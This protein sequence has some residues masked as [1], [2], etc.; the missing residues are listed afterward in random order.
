M[1]MST[2]MAFE[3]GAAGIAKQQYELLK[4]QQ[5]MASGRRVNSASD[6]PIAAAHIIDVTSAQE[7]NKRYLAN[8]TSARN[9]ISITESNLGQANSIL[10]DIRT[11]LVQA[12]DGSYGDRERADV[13]KEI[14]VRAEELL[15]L[16]N[17]KD[18]NGR[19]VFSGFQENIPAFRQTAA[20][21]VF[22]GDQGR[23]EVQVANGR[24]LGTSVSAADIFDRVRTGNGV[25]T[26]A[27]AAG[28]TGSAMIGL[29]QVSNAT[30]LDGH[31]YSLV[32]HVAAG[33]TTYDIVDDTAATTVS[34]GNA[35]VSG[36]SIGVA[37]MEADVSGPPADGDQFTLSPSGMRNVFDG[38]RDA[39]NLLRTGAGAAAPRAKLA[40]GVAETMAHVDRTLDQ[41]SQARTEA[42]VALG[43]LDR[44]ESATSGLDIGYEQQMSQLR[45]LDY[46]K[47]VSEMLRQQTALQAS[48]QSFGKVLG[49]SLFDYL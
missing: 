22:Q 15:A 25:F 31:S 23:R 21:V 8:Q 16:A 3:N 37:G 13:A 49:R 5:Q 39:V 10:Q 47:A 38:L 35:Y 11:L 19:Y 33:V 26:T 7:L 6:D 27:A 41:V 46:T 43:D 45:D 1:R 48:Q 34:A 29:G 24:T 40:M 28:N 44:L 12:G 17:S 30:A 32:F 9:D 18:A 4:T 20:G 36:S 14:E 2:S 42:G